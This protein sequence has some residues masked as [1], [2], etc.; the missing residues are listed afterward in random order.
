MLPLD[1]IKEYRLIYRY[2]REGSNFVDFP[3]EWQKGQKGT[4]ILL[5]GIHEKPNFLMTIAKNLHH[6]GFGVRTV[7]S[8][9]ETINKIIIRVILEI[10]LIIFYRSSVITHHIICFS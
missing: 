5:Q 3:R 10:F 4:V 2:K 1:L 8:Q 9:K 6:Q 7:Y